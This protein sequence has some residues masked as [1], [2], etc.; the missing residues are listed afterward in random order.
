MS[1]IKDEVGISVEKKVEEEKLDPVAIL[2]NAPHWVNAICIAAKIRMVSV[3]EQSPLWR[4]ASKSLAPLARGFVLQDLPAE[5]KVDAKAYAYVEEDKE[6]AYVFIFPPLHGGEDI[7]LL[8]IFNAL[9]ENGVV[10]G[11]LQSDLSDAVK[12][13]L[14]CRFIQVAKAQQPVKG[15][16]GKIKELIDPDTSVKFVEDDKGNID[17]K[18]LNTI[19]NIVTGTAICEIIP[20]TEGVDGIDVTRNPIPALSGKEVELPA[21]RNVIKSENEPYLVAEIEGN[22]TYR[23]E[24]YHVDNLLV[25]P[26]NID[27]STGNLDF[28]GDIQIRGDVHSGFSVK[29]GGSI[30]VGG[31]VEGGTLTAGQDIILSQGAHGA[32][33]SLFTAGGDI[34]AKFLEHCN[35]N[36][37]GDVAAG[38]IIGCDIASDGSINVTSGVGAIIGGTLRAH[39]TIEAKSIGNK[40]GVMTNLSLGAS[41]EMLE[42]RDRLNNEFATSKDTLQKLRQNMRFLDSVHEKTEKQKELAKV[43]K[44]QLPLYEAK[45]KELDVEVQEFTK[46]IRDYSP[47]YIKANKVYPTLAVSFGSRKRKFSDEYNGVRIIRSPEGEILIQE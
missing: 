21:G 25:I 14:Y 17:F 41:R 46:T 45:V 47:Y 9:Q 22:L 23:D 11:L 42:K 18:N 24:K 35:L 44:I 38:A 16:D 31:I 6:S 4:E 39:Q 43:I 1:E 13:K 8:S 29:A 19:N 2:S 27:V 37:G 10:F 33:S 7:S 40:T 34:H 32:K 5:E 36:C 12:N 15:E 26:G 20:P 30:F 3:P 28:L